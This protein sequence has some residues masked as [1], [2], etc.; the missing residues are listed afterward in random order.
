MFAIFFSQI[1]PE[2]LSIPLKFRRNPRIKEISN[3]ASMCHLFCRMFTLCGRYF[4]QI[5]QKI[6]GLGSRV[7]IVSFPVGNRFLHV[8][9]GVAARTLRH[10]VRLPVGHLCLIGLD[11]GKKRSHISAR[12]P[13]FCCQSSHLFLFRVNAPKKPGKRKRIERENENTPLLR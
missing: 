2:V 6:S 3:F 4:L 9:D 1:S 5:C 11:L 12:D 7:G 8:L 13:L 10:L